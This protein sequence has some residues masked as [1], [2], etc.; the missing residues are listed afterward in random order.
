MLFSKFC[1]YFKSTSFTEHLPNTASGPINITHKS[2]KS[3]TYLSVTKLRFYPYFFI[4]DLKRFNES[5]FFNV[6]TKILPSFRSSEIDSSDSIG[7][8]TFSLRNCGLG[9]LREEQFSFFEEN[10]SSL[11]LRD[12]LKTVIRT[13]IFFMWIVFMI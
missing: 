9:F 13:C 8:S 4:L 6:W 11:G 5:K 3:F 12:H 1:K 10:C 7:S 2:N